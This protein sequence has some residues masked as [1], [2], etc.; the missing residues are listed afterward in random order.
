MSVNEP[1]LV[2]LSGLRASLQ[3]K[4]LVTG[5]IPSQGTGLGCGSGSWQGVW[6]REPHIDVSLPFF[7]SQNEQIKP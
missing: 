4:G 2:W 3:S 6:E 7:P 5:S 1:S